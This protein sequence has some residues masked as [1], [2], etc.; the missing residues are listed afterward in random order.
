MKIE[1]ENNKVLVTGSSRGIGL[2]IANH[3]AINGAKVFYTARTMDSFNNSQFPMEIKE[4]VELRQCDFTDP[5]SISNLRKNIE[6]EISELDI[7]VCNVG[8]G[9]SVLDPVPSSEQFEKV[10]NLNF[11]SAVNTVREFLPLLEKSA[12]NILFISSI[13]GLEA[14]EAPIDYSVAKSAL[15]TFSKHLSKKLASKGIRVNCLALG[16][17]FFPGGVWDV[18]M[19]EDPLKVQA[20]LKA[21]VPM[22]RL[23]EVN[24]VAQASLFLCSKQASFITGAVLTVDGGQTSF[25]H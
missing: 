3:F 17:I 6:K 16:N 1:F 5:I 11:N 4:K 24:E 10:F 2:S 15:Q 13:C 25:F 22:N 12:G 9:K 8:S 21:H 14:Y 19:R 7:L 23:G 20:M 18:K